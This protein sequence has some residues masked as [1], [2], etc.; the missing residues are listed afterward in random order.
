MEQVE[1]SVIVP[2]YNVEEYIE[3]CLSGILRQTLADMEIL[4]INDGSTDG[5]YEIC[6][7]YAEADK[8][9][10]IICTDHVGLAE[11]RN[12]G[13]RNARGRYIGFADGDDD[14]HAT[15]FSRL[16]QTCVVNDS[17]IAVC[18]F[19]R[20]DEKGL[21]ET[22]EFLP[23]QCLSSKDAVKMLSEDKI[24]KNFVWNK[25]YRKALLEGIEFPKNKK[26]ED[27]YV[28][29]KLFAKAN[30]I[31]VIED[32]LYF[33]R[34]RQNSI[35][36]MTTIAEFEEMV[37][38]FESQVA[39][40]K[41]DYP[42]LENYAELCH[43]WAL[44]VLVMQC[45]KRDMQYKKNTVYINARKKLRGICRKAIR[46]GNVGKQVVLNGIFYMF[47]RLY[48]AIFVNVLKKL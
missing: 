14:V 2:A 48:I 19:Q 17:D 37:N 42:D 39:D 38:A 21:L 35:S 10:K 16:L 1:V 44:R 13:I 18:N 20:F 47:P 43:S 28:M 6:R 3:Q 12:I 5:T 23:E 11:V 34:N 4:V 25:L 22:I 24:M 31:A 26:Y 9:I 7:K 41:R 27:I 46:Q 8:R 15:M 30:K 36:H 45:M 29:E 32:K 40:V 33:Y